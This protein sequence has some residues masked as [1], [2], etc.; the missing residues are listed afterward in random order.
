MLRGIADDSGNTSDPAASGDGARGGNGGSVDSPGVA[1]GVGGA[2]T[3]RTVEKST[4]V[5]VIA[6]LSPASP[7]SFPTG[8][9]KGVLFAL[10]AALFSG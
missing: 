2:L 10:A 1:L 6:G 5:S 7:L 8:A 3:R 9:A 4:S